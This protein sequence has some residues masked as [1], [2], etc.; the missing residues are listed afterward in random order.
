[1]RS[2]WLAIARNLWRLGPFA[3]QPK[4]SLHSYSL[5]ELRERV[6]RT[7]RLRQNW[8]ISDPKPIGGFSNLDCRDHASGNADLGLTIE[9]FIPGVEI[10]LIYAFSGPLTCWNLRT[11]EKNTVSIQGTPLIIAAAFYPSEGR[12]IIPIAT[13]EFSQLNISCVASNFEAP[14]FDYLSL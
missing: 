10:L 11:R 3:C 2:V 5:V 7:V 6:L 4:D 9:V 14:Y 1:M 8:S 13:G 12:A